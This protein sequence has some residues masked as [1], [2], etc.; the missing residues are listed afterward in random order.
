MENEKNGFSLPVLLSLIAGFFTLS[1]GLWHLGYWSTFQFNYFEYANLTDLFKSSFYLF[2]GKIW[3]LVGLLLFILGASFFNLDSIRATENKIDSNLQSELDTKTQKKKQ[4]TIDIIIGAA[5][6][7]IGIFTSFTYNETAFVFLPIFICLVLVLLLTRINFLKKY[8]KNEVI[9][10]LIFFFFVVY[11]V[12]NFFVGKSTAKQ[13]INGSKAS[14]ITD[15][16]SDNKNLDTI[17]LGKPYLGSS[18]DF[19][20]VYA[21]PGQIEIIDKK[22]IKNYALMNTYDYINQATIIINYNQG[23]KKNQLIKFEADS[24]K[25]NKTTDTTLRK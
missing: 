13:I 17:L 16:N 22:T 5:L 3:P 25:R 15:I 12:A 2:F 23:Y 18:A 20:F 24:I 10:T 19:H 14:I 8:I 21:F 11:P 6:L 1:G 9:R 7:F 4:F